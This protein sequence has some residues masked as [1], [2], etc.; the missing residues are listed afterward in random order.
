MIYQAQIFLNLPLCLK[1]YKPCFLI[2]ALL[3]ENKCSCYPFR[4]MIVRL[5][6]KI[7]NELM[8][9][10]EAYIDVERVFSGFIISTKANIQQS[11]E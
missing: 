7:G 8:K 9:K 6:Q 2:A 3:I 4:L 11:I 5:L 10:C 1:T